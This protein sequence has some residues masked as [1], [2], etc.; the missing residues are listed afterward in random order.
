MF[1]ALAKAP[2]ILKLQIALF[3]RSFFLLRTWTSPS[4]VLSLHPIPP[5]RGIKLYNFSLHLEKKSPEIYYPEPLIVWF[6]ASVQIQTRVLLNKIIHAKKKSM[7]TF[8]SSVMK[9]SFFSVNFFMEYFC[10]H[11]D[12]DLASS[13]NVCL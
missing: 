10:L 9:W 2:S 7:K 1:L 6:S 3:S 13:A 12:I 4:F 5:R 11:I 8:L